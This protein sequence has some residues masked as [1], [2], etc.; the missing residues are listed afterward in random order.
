LPLSE[1]TALAAGVTARLPG[2]PLDR[3]LED[4]EFFK[5]A[6][7]AKALLISARA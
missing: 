5:A 2:R 6:T 4:E 7:E 3:A 1:F